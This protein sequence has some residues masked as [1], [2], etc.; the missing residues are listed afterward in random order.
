MRRDRRIRSPD[1]SCSRR[2]VARTSSSAKSVTDGEV[3]VPS[4]SQVGPRIAGC[5]AAQGG[6][7]GLAL[8][9]SW[10]PRLSG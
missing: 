9:L 5:P 2:R 4:R 8:R 1:A 10:R 3:H 6:Q 7:R